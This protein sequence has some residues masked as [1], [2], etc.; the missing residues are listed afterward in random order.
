MTSAP[1]VSLQAPKDI[2][3][4]QID[5]ELK[6][7]WKQYDISEEGI[8]A[9]R[10]STFTMVIYE[11]EPVQFLLAALGLYTGPVD[12]IAGA[13]TA[14]AIKAAQ[15]VYGLA[16]TG[17]SS[18]ELIN[19]LKKALIEEKESGIAHLYYS[20]DLA[21]AGIADAV[22]LANPC[23]IVTI[24]P[25]AEADEGVTVQVSAYCP[26]QKRSDNTLMCCEYITVRGTAEALDR[27][28]GLITELVI[29]E[30]PK[31]LWWKASPEPNFALFQRLASQSRAIIFDSSMFVHPAENL[32]EIGEMIEQKVPVADLNWARL[33]PWQE[34][35]AQAFD[36]IERRPMIKEVDEVVIDHEQGNETQAL[37]YLG[38]LASR[39]QWQPVSYKV[40]GGDYN[41]VKIG[42]RSE[43][44]EVIEV[45]LASVPIG[46]PGEVLG[47]LISL[48][49][50]STN[51]EA[52]CCTVLCSSTTGC[53]RMEAG[54]GA[55]SCYVQQVTS[56]ADQKTE[57]LIGKQLQRSGIDLLY[58]ESM[59]ITKTILELKNRN[60]DNQ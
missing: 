8:A 2:N 38:W 49:L 27:I 57:T 17:Y 31:F 45:E 50:S 10:A 9:T 21:G 52:D 32:L 30:L 26:V 47:D 29:P 22:A 12:G 19:C 35:T 40:E 7:I 46:D 34:L 36:P 58:I 13:R 3:I 24:C 14:A 16:E 53:M 48:R 11:P 39:L 42:F 60:K 18:P 56:M 15:K 6:A 4:D 23:R 37:M 51:P 41:I 28:G 1:L 54:G 44:K 55:Q 5:G 43:E 33:A 25:T 20:P 59:K